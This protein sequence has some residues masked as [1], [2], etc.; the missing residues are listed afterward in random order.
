MYKLRFHLTAAVLLLFMLTAAVQSQPLPRV[1]LALKNGQAIRLCLPSAQW[2]PSFPCRLADIS[3]RQLVQY[4]DTAISAISLDEGESPINGCSRWEA[5]HIATPS[6]LLGK[7]HT[8]LRLVG[9]VASADGRGTVYRWFLPSRHS[10]Q[11]ATAAWYGIRP[12]GSSVVYPFIQDGQ[13]WL[14]DL[15]MVFEKTHPEF[16]HA[17]KS[18]Y[19]K[20]KRSETEARKAR[21]MK[22]P[23]DILLRF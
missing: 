8:E 10:P 12:E 6:L 18:Y 20:G 7:Q 14:R 4:P 1:T 22:N 23:A 13:L 5:C 3:T 21:L 17:V 15:S 2:K 19:Q 9:V 16:V 11:S